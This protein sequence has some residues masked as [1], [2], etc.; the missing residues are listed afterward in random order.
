MISKFNCSLRVFPTKILYIYT[1]R[2]V[3]LRAGIVHYHEDQLY[4]GTS[5]KQCLKWTLERWRRYNDGVV[6]PP[7][8]VPQPQAQGSS[9]ANTPLAVLF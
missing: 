4:I 8:N 5:H 2:M 6:D 3:V 7:P 1:L 9:R